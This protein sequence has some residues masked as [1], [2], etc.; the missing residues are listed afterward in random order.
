MGIPK[1][2]HLMTGKKQVAVLMPVYQAQAD[3]DATMESLAE[4]ST[5]FTIFVVDDGSNPPLVLSGSAQRLEVRL[6]RL[7]RNQG[8][9]GALNFGLAA[10]LES[11]YQYIARIDAGDFLTPNRLARQS[12]YLDSH[13]VCG[14][15]GSD[16]IVRSEDGQYLFTIEPPRNPKA[17]ARGLHERM[18]LMHPGIML[19]ADVLRE[20]GFY[21]D[22]YTAAEDYELI[23]RVAARYEVGVVPEPLLTYIVR[24]G[25]ISG[26]K[27]RVQLLSRLR[28]QLRYFRW[29]TWTSYYGVLRTAATLLIPRAM[30]SALKL[31]FLYAR[32]P[33]QARIQAL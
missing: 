18:W 30:K 1:G 17:L 21:T 8:I 23:L 7:E 32:R 25:S 28:I 12:A 9:V 11:G 31:R 20:T 13:P 19:R 29:A 33:A 6:L 10:V 14:L 26:R 27:S 5:P 2:E 22:R 16:T 3:F 4:V 24:N 15:V